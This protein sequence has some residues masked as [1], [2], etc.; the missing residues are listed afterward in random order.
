V[1]DGSVTM[2]GF[3][4]VQRAVEALPQAVTGALRSVA[5]RTAVRV[6]GRAKMILRSITS[7]TGATANALR[8]TERDQ[9]QA[10]IVDV[11]PVI[12]RP[13]NLPLWLELGTVK[14]SAR[15]FLRPAMEEASADYVR[16][17]EAAVVH[18]AREALT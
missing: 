11:G 8:V 4:E 17:A 18:V 14:M 9:M 16:D 5:Q 15:P 10:F 13:D 7:G 3:R 2:T 6:Q 12:G 1:A